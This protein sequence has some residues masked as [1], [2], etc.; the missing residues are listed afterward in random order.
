MKCVRS[1]LMQRDAVWQHVGKCDD[2]REE[3]LTGVIYNITGVSP[4]SGNSTSDFV[5][6][7]LGPARCTDVMLIRNRVF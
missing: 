1:T 3:A 2:R 5:L 6:V 4:Q 7:V